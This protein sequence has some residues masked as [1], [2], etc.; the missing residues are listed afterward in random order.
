[1]EER[2]DEAYGRLMF[3]EQYDR[4]AEILKGQSITGIEKTLEHKAN[5]ETHA[6]RLIG[7]DQFIG[8]ITLQKDVEGRP[9]IGIS[10]KS[11]YQNKGIGPEAVRLFVNRLYSD[12]GIQTVYVRIS[13]ENLQSQRGFAKLGAILDKTEPHYILASLP[14]DIPADNPDKRNLPN[15]RFYHINLPV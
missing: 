5:D 6:I 9:D 13:E 10:L 8:W 11:D 1:M 3:G 15:L 7:D 14:K 12:Y 4:F 2:D